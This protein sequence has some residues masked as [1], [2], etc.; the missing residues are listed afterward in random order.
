MH[1]VEL[2]RAIRRRGA[3][4]SN[5]RDSLFICS[6]PTRYLGVALVERA[7][8]PRDFVAPSRELRVP[9]SE[10]RGSL[11]EVGESRVELRACGDELCV[12]GVKRGVSRIELTEP[13]GQLR[14]Q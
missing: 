11:S 6:A 4:A 8:Q 3:P 12:Q 5:L 7:A 14:R 13:S 10:V 2:T 9:V 1:R